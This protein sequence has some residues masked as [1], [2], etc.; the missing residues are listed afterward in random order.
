LLGR[1]RSA[2]KLAA[3]E[4][5]ASLDWL[6]KRAGRESG[7]A[8]RK[9]TVVRI[10][11]QGGS[12]V[13]NDA[14]NED[15]PLGARRGPDFRDG[16]DV[17]AA[18]LQQAFGFRA[19]TFGKGAH[20]SERQSAL[21][22][23]FDAFSDLAA[24][25]HLPHQM[26]GF[27]DRITLN[28][29]AGVRGVK[30]PTAASFDADDNVLHIPRSM[31]AGNLAQTWGRAMSGN[32]ASLL[33][34]DKAQGGSICNAIGRGIEFSRQQ[35]TNYAVGMKDLLGKLVREPITEAEYLS[36]VSGTSIAQEIER[37][38]RV[39]EHEV[40]LFEPML[41]EGVR[42]TGEFLDTASRMLRNRISNGVDKRFADAYCDELQGLALSYG[43]ESNIQLRMLDRVAG[44]VKL[45]FQTV[46][47]LV[48]EQERVSGYGE[49][50]KQG[51]MQMR[52]TQFYE[53]AKALDRSRSKPFYSTH[54]ELWAR[55]LACFIEDRLRAA[56]GRNDYL[57]HS[58]S[59]DIGQAPEYPRGA[60]R[61]RMHELYK[62]YFAGAGPELNHDFMVEQR[63]ATDHRAELS[64]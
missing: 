17:T 22:H 33:S 5:G 57:V 58:T 23:A 32:M 31:T 2:P 45:A 11:S 9:S 35:T 56:G 24:A 30:A 1:E 59:S 43:A 26:I 3:L 64:G 4:G 28:L 37:F 44:R 62:A 53:T 50:V 49:L 27:R 12:P 16:K 38:A 36:A 55:G 6:A 39:V 10:A 46:Q 60:E 20:E 41:P 52:P 29:C 25:V 54:E 40:K 21:N 63:Q 42:L 19:V 18:V 15:L 51:H 7:A 8:P 13:E 61:E 14:D 47:D 34:I 48:L